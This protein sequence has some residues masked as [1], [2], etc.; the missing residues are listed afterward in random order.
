MKRLFVL[1][2][3]LM[4]VSAY[5]QDPVSKYL[6]NRFGG[7]DSQTFIAKGS[8]ALSIKGGYR[9][10]GSLGDDDTNAGYALLSLLNIGDAQLRIWNISPSYSHFI[11][12][13]LSLGVSLDYSGY[14]ADTDLKLDLRDILNASSENLNV[15][16]S[17]RSMR[18]HVGG[19]SVVLRKYMPLFGSK[20]FAIFG[21]GRLQGSY[22]TTINVPRDPGDVNRERVS[23]VYGVALKAGGGL[24]L[25]LGDN[26]LTVSLPLFGVSYSHTIQ[27]RSTTTV[28][29]DDQGH[30]VI[31]TVRSKTHMSSFNAA[32]NLD[33]LGIQVGFTRY[34]GPKK[35]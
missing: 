1:A 8:H 21:E 13:D 11:A 2:A 15:S 26:A 17:K 30:E 12:D 22:G 29:T 4:S 5:A 32:R 34:I 7:P 20:Y 16:L 9:S 28:E 23:Q 27:N 35:K 6:E 10:F 19:A 14:S 31:K 25:K 3:M 24:A 18:H 33:L